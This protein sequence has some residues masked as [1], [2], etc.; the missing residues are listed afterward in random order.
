MKSGVEL[1]SWKEGTEAEGRTR[2]PFKWGV[3][4]LCV[5]DGLGRNIQVVLVKKKKQEENEGGFITL[6]ALCKV[7]A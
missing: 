3:S 1:R 4:L 5:T 2:C 6:F 7:S